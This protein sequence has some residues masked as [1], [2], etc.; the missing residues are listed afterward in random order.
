MELPRGIRRRGGVLWV[1]VRVNGQRV[2]RPAGK[3]LAEAERLRAE[4]LAGKGSDPKGSTFE[5]LAE[6]YLAK[7]RITGKAAS[8]VTAESVIRRLKH[9]FGDQPPQSLTADDLRIYQAARL[10]KVSR[11]AIN[12]EARYLRCILRLAVDEGLLEKVP[13]KFT[14]LRTPRKSPT[15]LTPEE[16]RRLLA[17]AGEIRPLLLAA[18]YTGLR[19]GEL[20]ALRW[21]D[22]DLVE[23]VLHVAARDGWSPKS[24]RDRHVPLHPVVVGELNALRARA[25]RDAAGDAVFRNCRDK[26]WNPTHLSRAV[27]RAYKMAKL[28]RKEDKPGLHM[29]RRTF[30][31][32][33]LHSGT[34]IETARELAGHSSVIVTQAYLSSTD[35]VKRRAVEGL[36]F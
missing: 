17:A 11:E 21:R 13:F 5:D 10:A 28:Y 35:R 26:A 19:N 32:T 25:A 30:L 3:T 7:L 2:R 8:V 22:V 29:L 27:R 15:I 6:K 31:S 9:H 12:K 20:C 16:T 1:D 36:A 33:L 4:I 23:G 24:H 18:A 14:M 34:D